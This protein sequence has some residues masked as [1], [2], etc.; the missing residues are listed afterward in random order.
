MAED[1]GVEVAGFD[2]DDRWFC[3]DCDG[4]FS[5]VIARMY[6]PI[7]VDGAEVR[8]VNAPC[9]PPCA[10][11]RSEGGLGEG[12]RFEGCPDELQEDVT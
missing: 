7:R 9:C 1:G 2:P 11:R 4:A 10:A 3:Q 8:S 6:L 12:Q 5:F